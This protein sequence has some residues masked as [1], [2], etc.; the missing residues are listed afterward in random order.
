MAG[1]FDGPPQE[2]LTTAT[3]SPRRSRP[4]V[5]GAIGAIRPRAGSGFPDGEARVGAASTGVPAGRPPGREVPPPPPPR[6]RRGRD[7]LEHRPEE[8]LGGPFGVEGV[9]PLV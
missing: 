6:G 7:E 1:N 2:G 3:V 8:R 9:R 4:G 5:T